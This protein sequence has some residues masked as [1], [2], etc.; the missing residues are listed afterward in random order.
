LFFSQVATLVAACRSTSRIF[1]RAANS[2][3]GRVLGKDF[4]SLTLSMLDTFCLP[5]LLYGL[6]ALNNKIATLITIDFVYNSVFI[7]VFGV[8]DTYNILYCQRACGCLPASCRLD[9]R[10]LLFFNSLQ[11]SLCSLMASQLFNFCG[12]LG[13]EAIIQK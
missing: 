11:S 9:I 1:F 2:I 10:T 3:L 12:D 8:K 5:V 6:E 13:Y 4:S 7:K